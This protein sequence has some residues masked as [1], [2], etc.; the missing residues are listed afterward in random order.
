MNAFTEKQEAK[1]DRL[2]A[3]ADRALKIY[4][5]HRQASAVD[6]IDHIIENIP[7]RI[8]EI[9]TDDWPIQSRSDPQIGTMEVSRCR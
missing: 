3:A 5:K 4:E 6:F 2:N 1:R 7:F 9:R 8:R